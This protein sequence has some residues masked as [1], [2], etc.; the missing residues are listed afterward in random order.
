MKKIYEFNIDEIK[1]IIVKHLGLEENN[2]FLEIKDD[3][4]EWNYM[5]EKLRIV[6][7]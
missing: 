2:I 6:A 1:E 3:E 4:D 5:C 7:E